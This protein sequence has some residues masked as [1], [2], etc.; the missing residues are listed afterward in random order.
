MQQLRCSSSGAAAQV[1][2]SWHSWVLAIVGHSWSG[3]AAQVQQLR[4]S[5]SGA[6]ATSIRR[7]VFAT[8]ISVMEDAAD[9]LQA[10]LYFTRAEGSRVFTG[11]GAVEADFTLHAHG[12][13]S[14][15]SSK[16]YSLTIY[17]NIYTDVSAKLESLGAMMC[18]NDTEKRRMDALFE[19]LRNA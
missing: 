4:C 14:G 3:A 12:V 19:R 6:A 7:R 10:G 2:H 16:R 8:S 13:T 11:E 5:S 1:Q 15:C 18:N 17:N 9:A